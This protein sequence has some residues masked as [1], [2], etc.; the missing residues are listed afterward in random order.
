[1]NNKAAKAIKAQK[2]SNVKPPSS[3]RKNTP[4]T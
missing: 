3:Q 2:T 4:S 1:M